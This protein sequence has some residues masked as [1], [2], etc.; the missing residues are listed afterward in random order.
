MGSSFTIKIP[1]N[2]TVDEVSEF[3]TEINSLVNMGR[4]DFVI[5]FSECDFIDS[6]GLGALVSVYKKCAEHDGKIKLISLNAEVK[7]L[8]ELTRLDRV[9]E[10]C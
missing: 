4:I 7:K 5:D 8:F 10:I 3:R 9:F 2:F 6:T 1:K